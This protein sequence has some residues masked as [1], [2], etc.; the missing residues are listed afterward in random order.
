MTHVRL[1][2]W[3]DHSDMERGGAF[4]LCLGVAERVQ[5]SLAPFVDLCRANARPS[6]G[7][8]RGLPYTNAH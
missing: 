6:D 4:D 7:P 5:T 3:S 1:K 2:D 8:L